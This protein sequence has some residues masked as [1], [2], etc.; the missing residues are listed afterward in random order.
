[1]VELHVRRYFVMI[2]IAFLI[3]CMVSGIIFF[4]MVRKKFLQSS[5]TTSVT[6]TKLWFLHVS[7]TGGQSTCTTLKKYWHFGPN[8]DCNFSPKS[9]FYKNPL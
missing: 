9:N 2:L 3:T 7:R 8:Y 5:L 1:M 4:N 6:P